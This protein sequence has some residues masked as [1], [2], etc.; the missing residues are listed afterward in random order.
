MAKL[1][2]EI[3]TSERKSFRGC[4]LRWKWH[5]IDEWTPIGSAPPL[6]FGIAYHKA[7][8]VLYNPETWDLPSREVVGELAVKTFVD[9]CNKQK[10]AYLQESGQED[11]DHEV[12]K[13]YAERIELGK[14]MLR[15]FYR[16]QLPNNPEKL[17]PVKVEVAFEVPITNPW[18]GEELFCK[19]KKCFERWYATD[20]AKQKIAECNARHE[21]KGTLPCDPKGHFESTGGLPVVY[22]GRIDAL[23][24]DENG[25][26]WII[27]WKTTAQITEDE[28]FLELDS[29]IGSYVWALVVG[30]GLPVRGF[31]YH[32]QR[33]GYPQP[34][35]RN[36]HIR[37]GCAFSVSKSQTTDYETFLETVKTEDTAAYESGAYD[38]FLDFLKHEGIVY[39]KRDIVIKTP[40]QLRSIHEDIYNEVL[41]MIDPNLRIYRNDGRFSCKW[42]AFRQPCLDKAR[43]ADYEYGLRTLFKKQPPY[44][45]RQQRGASTESKGG[46]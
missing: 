3:H 31:I 9:E 7:M 38:E 10:Q 6:E 39:Y 22:A 8:E 43:G 19:C 42:C 20:E 16:K 2:H 24:E 15:Y 44:Y 35:K 28:E 5:F 1:V 23:G 18:T 29:Q 46:E 11:F 34:P 30:L 21:A 27:D 33:K 17:R 41:D 45:Y 13:D 25:D 40:E 37:L 12:E 36:K 26:Y 4:R 14:G 32:Q